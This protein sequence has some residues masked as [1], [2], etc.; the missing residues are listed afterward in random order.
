[1]WPERENA[2]AHYD[3]FWVTEDDAQAL[4][5]VLHALKNNDT[6]GNLKL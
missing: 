1:M 4:C 5:D 3:G 6:P 2:V